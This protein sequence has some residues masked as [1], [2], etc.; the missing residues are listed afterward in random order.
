MN[1]A[2]WERLFGFWQAFD[3]PFTVASVICAAAGLIVTPVASWL[4]QRAGRIDAKLAS[5]IHVRWKSWLGLVIV[6]F[7]TVLLGAAFLMAGVAVLSLLCY[8]E[9]ARATGL[10]REKTIGFVVV[11]GI[12]L[13]TFAVVDHYFKLFF[14]SPALVVGALAIATIPQD[15]PKGYVQRVALGVLG[16]LLFGFFLGYIGFMG[17]HPG[18]RPIVILMVLAVE[19]NDIF[20]FCVGKTLGGPKLL[21]QTSPGKTV[22]G[23]LGA[24]VLTTALC[25]GLGSLVFSGTPLAR[26]D[27]LLI[28]GSG[29]SLLGQLGDLLLSSIKRDAGVKD[30]GHSIPGHGGFLDRFDSLVLVPP[31]LFHFVSLHLGTWGAGQAERI[32]SGG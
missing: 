12:F 7:M 28:F 27:S 17:N 6:L 24:L 29:L 11:L 16:F 4:L 26:W 19:L 18:Y 9:Y 25:V 22:A 23:S 2:T 21:P 30:L 13:V 3:H 31:A 32:L 1:Q 5:E 14:A 20:A 15:R 10:F 8:R